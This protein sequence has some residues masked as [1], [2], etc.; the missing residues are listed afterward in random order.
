MRVASLF[1]GG[2]DSMTLLKIL[3]KLSKRAPE[4]KIIAI[5]ID[6]GTRY[7]KEG[8]KISEKFL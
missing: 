8:L 6:E 5:S 1:S 3:H 4:S 7:R 2:K